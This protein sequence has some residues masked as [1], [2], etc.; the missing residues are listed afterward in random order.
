MTPSR[1]SSTLPSQ[2]FSIGL[3]SILALSIA[4]RFWG[5]SR[6]NTLVFDEVYFAKFGYNYLTH[7]PFFD[8]H[9]PLGKYFIAFGIWLKGFNPFGYRWMNALIGSLIPLVIAGI[10][11]QLSHRRSYALIAGLF[12]AAD[13]LLLVESR[14]ALI[15]I[16]LLILG[17]LGQWFFLLALDTQGKQ[18]WLWLTL[19]GI[20][21]GGTIAVKWNGLG[22]LLG[23]YLTWLCA[24]IEQLFSRS[25]RRG[26]N[27]DA[28]DQTLF[29]KL[30]QLN[31]AQ[32]LYPPAL[33]AVVYCLVWIPH[34]QLNPTPSFWELQKQMLTYHG[35]IGSGPNVHPYCSSWY[36]WPWMVRP[37]DYFYQ[38]ALNPAEPVPVVGP[39][40]PSGAAKVIYDVHAIGNPA[41][42]WLSTAAIIIL[43][44]MLARQLWTWVMTRSTVSRPSQSYLTRA[45]SFEIPVY[46]L[47]NYAANFLPW[48]SVSRCTF[49]YHYMPAFVFSLLAIAWLI[50]RWLQSNQRWLRALG[51]TAI[52]LILAS[53]VFWL[54]IYLGL[55]LTPEGFRAR[56]WFPSW[57]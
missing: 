11:Y 27:L 29:Q 38:T 12:A 50:D 13:G 49:L 16:Y 57:I 10:A 22:F 51:L 7:T 44:W 54:P 42:W 52:F 2:W 8:S 41:L 20:S 31:F 1:K 15:N 40:L 37:V 46:L 48:A 17:L 5:L 24:W 35:R 55:P 18:P 30:R 43:L 45:T 39:P 6:F 47:L 23:I 21:L 56:M 32:L 25:M 36:T 3:V 34:R 53:L 28:P 9:P 19:S 4:L 14:Y 33:S 26:S